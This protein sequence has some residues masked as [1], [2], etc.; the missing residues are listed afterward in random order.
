VVG[1]GRAAQDGPMTT[2][3]LA[4]PPGLTSAAGPLGPGPSPTRQRC[5]EDP[6]HE[7]DIVQGIAEPAEQRP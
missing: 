3:A 7:D 2:L 5:L 4:A 1:A 6:E